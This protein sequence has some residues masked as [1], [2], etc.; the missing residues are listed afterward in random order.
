MH[1]VFKG[2]KFSVDVETITLRNGRAHIVETVRHAPSVV[3]MPML[4]ADRV[5]LV[6]QRRHSVNRD[7]WE[8]PAGGVNDGESAEAAASRECEEEIGLVPEVVERVR[9]LYPAPGF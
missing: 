9:A 6:R 2:R 7:L 3:L 4:D 5:M 1:V 8:L